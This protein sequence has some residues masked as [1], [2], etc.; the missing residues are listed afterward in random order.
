VEDIVTEQELPRRRDVLKLAAAG[1]G[2][3]S[4]SLVDRYASA[5]EPIKVNIVNTSP[6]S[7][8]TIQALLKH[9]HWLEDFGLQPTTLNV[10]DGSKLMGAL[11]SGSSDIC[12]LSGFS[13]VL[14]AD[15][16][17]GKVKMLAGAQLLPSY[18]VFSKKPE[19]KTIKD[20]EG[21]T[22]ATGSVGALL[23]QL[24]AAIL[25]KKGVDIKKVKFVNAGSSANVFRAVA[26]GTVD[27]GPSLYDVYEQ[28]AKYG[29]HSLEDGNL[30]TE[31]PEYTYQG[32]YAA[33]QAIAQKRDAL[34]RV[35][36]AYCKAYR[37]IQSPGSREDYVAARKAALHGNPKTAEAE[38]SSEWRFNQKFKPYATDLVLSKERIDYMQKLN[39]SLGSQKDML[40][41]D[42]VADMSLAKDALK[43]LG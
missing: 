20:L 18:A 31:L 35:L 5:A 28:Q 6:N 30:W 19:I 25:Q 34:V 1:A 41:Y 15:A 8:F 43:L 4:L 37:Y 38:A 13:Q 33:E 27:A 36:A 16:K 39:I 2:V 11:F 22:V 21:K 32:S 23:Y 29:V 7:A 24:M 40:P 14:A 10:S 42:Q 26:A 17:G 3:L 9:K 12:L